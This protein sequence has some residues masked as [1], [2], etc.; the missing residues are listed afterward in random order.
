MKGEASS[1]VQKEELLRILCFMMLRTHSE[2]ISDTVF[3][4]HQ[5]GI[6]GLL[7]FV[8]MLDVIGTCI[9]VEVAGQAV[10]YVELICDIFLGERP[11][12]FFDV[13]QKDVLFSARH[14]VEFFCKCPAYSV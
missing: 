10:G 4:P 1:V 13:S 7:K 11:C 3:G 6:R 5:F 12:D 2:F 9:L 14:A 8:C